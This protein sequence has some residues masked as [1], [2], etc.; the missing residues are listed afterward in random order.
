MARTVT[1][2]PHTA[3]ATETAAAAGMS[4]PEA[5]PLTQQ[6]RQV[7]AA[8]MALCEPLSTEDYVVQSMPDASPAKW[9]LAHTSWSFEEF[10][11]SRAGGA[12]EFHDSDFRFLFNSYYNAVGPMHTAPTA[13]CCRDRPCGR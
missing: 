11:L 7:R 3:A 5:P 1:R 6:Y 12:Y 8:S 13:V 2:L 10:V 4:V 9:H